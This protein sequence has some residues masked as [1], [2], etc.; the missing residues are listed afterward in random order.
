MHKTIATSTMGAMLALTLALCAAHASDP[1]DLDYSDV[2]MTR[3]EFDEPF[4]RDGRAT[5]VAQIL[6]VVAG[7][8][9]DQVRGLIGDPLRTGQGVR[10]PEW[11]YDLKLDLAD[12]DFIVC[13]YKVV[14]DARN[15]AVV[16]THWRR[17]QCR[18]AIAALSAHAGH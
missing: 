3:P 9:P 12:E 6:Q 10:G 8:T 13:Q 11:D 5:P 2:N 1:P 16:E 18:D 15:A 7:A 4:Q 14:F 17:Y